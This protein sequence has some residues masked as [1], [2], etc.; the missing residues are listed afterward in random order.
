MAVHQQQPPGHVGSAET[1]A[2]ARA[3]IAFRID[4]K[5]ALRF[6]Y[7]RYLTPYD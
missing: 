2:A 3:G 5:T 1:R 7:A 4:D 6:G